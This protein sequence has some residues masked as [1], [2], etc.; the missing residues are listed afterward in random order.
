MPGEGG[1]GSVPDT[2]P[3]PE[4]VDGDVA[5]GVM[6]EAFAIPNE[7]VSH[8]NESAKISLRN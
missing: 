7:A 3:D 5:A 4:F 2:I 6:V 1:C 8:T